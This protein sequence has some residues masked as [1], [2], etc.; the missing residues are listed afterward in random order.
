MI[1]NREIGLRLRCW[2]PLV[3][4]SGCGGAANN[5]TDAS[6]IDD[7]SPAN[8]CAMDVPSSYDT[9]SADVAA[10]DGKW[11]TPGMAAQGADTAAALCNVGWHICTGRN[12]IHGVSGYR[13]CENAPDDKLF[14]TQQSGK[15]NFICMN[16][17]SNGVFGC[18]G[19]RRTEATPSGFFVDPS[20]P[21][22]ACSPLNAM[23]GEGWVDSGGA[24]GW[25]FA[26]MAFQNELNKVIKP[27]LAGGGVLCCR[28]Q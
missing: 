9:T 4:A 2:L 12:E 15:G 6:I 3:L 1:S 10:C 25:S 24:A 21:A 8:G 16:T 17:G 14:L 5:P 26:A 13:V 22:Y 28:N 18:S 7:P 23:I 11:M 20:N 27:N 19:N